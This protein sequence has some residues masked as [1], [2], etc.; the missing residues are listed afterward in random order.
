MPNFKVNDSGPMENPGLTQD[1]KLCIVHV[2]SQKK[3]SV[4]W[5]MITTRQGDSGKTKILSG[6]PV[7]K[8]SLIIECLGCTDEL[9]SLVA[10]LRL[11][12]MDKMPREKETGEF[13]LW[14][15]HALFATGSRI[16][17]PHARS[18]GEGV[19]LTEKHLLKLE[20]HMKLLEKSLNLPKSFIVSASNPISAASDIIRT[21]VRTLERRVVLL[22]D[23]NPDFKLKTI[24]VFLNRLSDYFFILARYLDGG[25]VTTVNYSLLDH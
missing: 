25:S 13:L 1:G 12:V 22:K 9:S 14:I 20:S 7:S 23:E 18:T 10:L 17:D 16:S 19:T 8:G 21:R 6:E 24:L 15:L 3:V 4:E 5:E 11:K 2:L